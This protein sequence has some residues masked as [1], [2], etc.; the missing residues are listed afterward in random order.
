MRLNYYTQMKLSVKQIFNGQEREEVSAES[1]PLAV[2][3]IL[4]FTGSMA[5]LEFFRITTPNSQAVTS[6]ESHFCRGHKN[7]ELKLH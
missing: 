2:I 3:I 4:I 1:C 6:S 7:S 5:I